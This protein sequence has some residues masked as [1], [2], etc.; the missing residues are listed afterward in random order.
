MTLI[1]VIAVIGANAALLAAAIAVLLSM[2]RADRQF[3]R[4]SEDSLRIRAL[5]DRLREDLHAADVVR[6]NEGAKTLA[7]VAADGGAIE[8]R[9]TSDRV[10]R[11]TVEA[12]SED[13]TTRGG[14]LTSAFPLPAGTHMTVKPASAVAGDLVHIALPVEPD[15]PQPDRQPPHA[16]EMVAAV[17]RDLRLLHE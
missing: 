3:A 9:L 6:W 16:S 11:W 12:D 7:L 10:E 8:Y 4:R 17:G 14:K 2:G 13:K 15:E 1:E 5:C